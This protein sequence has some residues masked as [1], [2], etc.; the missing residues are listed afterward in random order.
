MLW[1]ELYIQA[2]ARLEGY[3]IEEMMQ[4]DLPPSV[5]LIFQESQSPIQS[6]VLLI[7]SDLATS[8]R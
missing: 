7:K 8:K 5:I 4:D 6:F 1:H 3:H 2:F